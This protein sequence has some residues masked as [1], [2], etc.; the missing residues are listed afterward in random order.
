MP[1]KAA[2]PP[3]TVRHSPIHGRGVFATAAIRRGR[4]I[5]EYTGERI[6]W[7][8]DPIPIEASTYLFE[9]DE[10]TVIDPSRGGNEAQYINHS[11]APNC[12]PYLSRGRVYIYALRNIRP[13]EELCYDYRL[14]TGAEPTADDIEGYACRCGAR[15]CRGTL[16]EPAEP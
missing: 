14:S 13:G 11:C 7:S 1:T 8:S 4:R 9:V 12:E 10:N 15:A 6:A 3:I 2:R 5:I 16:L